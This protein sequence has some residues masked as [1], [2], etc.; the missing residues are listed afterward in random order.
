[1]FWPVGF[2]LVSHHFLQDGDSEEMVTTIGCSS[3]GFPGGAADTA[4]L[5]LTTWASELAPLFSVDISLER[6]EVAVGPSSAPIRA[7]STVGPE[8]GTASSGIVLPNTSLLVRKQTALGGRKGRGRMYWPGFG[9]VNNLQG[10]GTILGGAMATFQAAFD[11]W[12]TALESDVG[13]GAIGNLYLFHTEEE[14]PTQIDAVIVQQRL[15]TQRRRL[16]P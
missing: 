13:P 16:R 15:A 12:Q 1:M 14:A 7:N 5:F 8:P 9:Q 6:V 3:T 10:N 4:D 2:A 11:D